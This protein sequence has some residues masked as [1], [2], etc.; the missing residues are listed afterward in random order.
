MKEQL[1]KQLSECTILPDRHSAIGEIN[2]PDH[3]LYFSDILG[4]YITIGNQ[5]QEVR[6]WKPIKLKE[7]C[8]ADVLNE[9]RETFDLDYC[10]VVTD[11]DYFLYCVNGRNLLKECFLKEDIYQDDNLLKMLGDKFKPKDV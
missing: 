6:Y 4:I 1:F 2:I 10:D 9:L 8:S 7:E 5:I 3:S 11:E